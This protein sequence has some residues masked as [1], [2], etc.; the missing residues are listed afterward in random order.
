[1]DHLSYFCIS[2]V[3]RLRLFIAAL[4]SAEGKWLTSC[5][6]LDVYCDIVTFIFGILVQVW[7]LIVLIP[8]SGCLFY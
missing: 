2:F 3:M 7:Y 1:M 4:W 6:L 5:L 8:D